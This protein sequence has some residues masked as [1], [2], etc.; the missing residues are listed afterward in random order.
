M[1]R[2]HKE[3]L[4]LAACWVAFFVSVIWWWGIATRPIPD[5]W[6]LEWQYEQPI[7]IVEGGS[8]C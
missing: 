8:S 2:T 4:F 3:K 7:W 5:N 1:G 6:F